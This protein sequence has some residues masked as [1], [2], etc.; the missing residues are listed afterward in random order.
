MTDELALLTVAEMAKADALA[1]AGGTPG[2]ALME[3]AGSA[4]AEEAMRR[5]SRR[6]AVVLC[7]P[8]NNGGDGFVAAR[9]LRE[10][11]WPVRLAFLGS[12]ADLRG[13]AALA[14]ARWSGDVQ[15]FEP[16][17]LADKPLVVDALLGAGLTRPV[18]GVAHAVIT[19]I[20]D[21]RL[22]CIAVDLPSGVH[23]DTGQVLGVA[24]RCQLT[25]TFFR[26]KLGHVL[27]PGRT[28]CGET[29]TSDIGIPGSVLAKIGSRFRDNQPAAWIGRYPWP[30][31]EDHKYSRGHVLISGGPIMT[32][33][34]RLAASAARR[35][36]AGLVTIACSAATHVIY[37]MTSP[38]VIAAI[39]D[40]D[41]D[42]QA[43]LADSRRNA[44]LVGPGH[45]LGDATKRRVLA[46]LSAGKRYVLDADGLT[47][48][49][50][51]PEALFKTIKSPCVLTPHDGEFARLF[52]DLA[53]LPGKLD[54][55]IAAA[56]R[57]GAVVLLKGSDTVIAD[58]DGRALI[59]TN[60]PPSLATGGSGDVLAGLIVA[61]LAQGVEPLRAAGMAAWVQGAAAAK[62]GPGLIAE[63]IVE[64]I[65]SILNFIKA[66]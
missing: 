65:P 32:G 14:A 18:E 30:R 44:V 61:Y 16:A 28:Y 21:R 34:A 48:F 46:A 13:D 53:T 7:G 1:I 11:G 60:A 41:E 54:R 64:Q 10:A 20:N 55:A 47:V 23:G 43:L 15:D 58:P 17:I 5:W 31:P 63:D 51:R 19:A 26:R 59:N 9:R 8:G 12:R 24:P 45:G 40:R 50:D 6:P 25:V 22:P 35:A 52:P 39:A 62:F 4:V 38:G 49:A 33:A 36:G 27:L 42:F 3:N 56:K 2:I 57:S 66:I 37:A 29:V